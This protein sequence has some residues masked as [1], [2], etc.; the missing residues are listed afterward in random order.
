VTH[1]FHPLHGREYEVADRRTTWGEDR[2]YFYDE[3]GR[4]RRMPVDWTNLAIQAPF[5]V[6]SA[7]R[8]WFRIDDLVQLADLVGRLS[9]DR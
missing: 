3:T 8:S 6:L 9:E 1:P 4:L 2:V 5:E 7:G